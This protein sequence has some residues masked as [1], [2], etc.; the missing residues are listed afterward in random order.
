[1]KSIPK[2]ALT[3]RKNGF[4]KRKKEERDWG[5]MSLCE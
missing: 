1:M 2:R 5:E 4:Q 3:I